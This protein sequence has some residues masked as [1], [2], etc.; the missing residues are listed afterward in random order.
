MPDAR[1]KLEVS[2]VTTFPPS[3]G[4]AKKVSFAAIQ[5]NSIPEN[6]LFQ[7]ATPYVEF[8]AYI[9]NPAVLEK[10]IPGKAFYVD[11]TAVPELAPA[12]DEA[13]TSN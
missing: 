7:K 3:Y 9:N 10:L 11:F 5:D 2:S 1:M 13:A 8:S 6:Q 4:D 12:A